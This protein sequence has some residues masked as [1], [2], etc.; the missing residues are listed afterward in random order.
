MS[1]AQPT[2]RAHNRL[3]DAAILIFVLF[4]PMVMTWTY[5]VYG[6]GLDPSVSKNLYAIG[7]T[8]QFAFPALVAAFVLKERVLVRRFNTRGLL[9][10]ALFGLV[11]GTAIFLLGR[12]FLNVP[13]ALSA[14]FDKLRGE[15]VARLEQFGAASRGAF[16][17]IGLFY[18]II[19]SGLEEYYWRWFTFGR[20]AK[21]L[22]VVPAAL[23]ANGAFT[24][25]HIVVLGVYFGFGHWL[26][27]LTSLGVF[28]GG[29]VWQ[30]IYRKTDSVYGAWLSHGLIDAGIF[31]I[32]YLLMP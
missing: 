5:F 1:D 23:V 22:P 18:S 16:L 20:V 17:V 12:Y 29:L 10:G 9:I 31:A 14:L 24:L 19:H 21:F 13:T 3:R 15:L 28:I 25:H 26:T 11:V 7:K 2:E 30:A 27:W 32:G 4:F 8:L 6:K